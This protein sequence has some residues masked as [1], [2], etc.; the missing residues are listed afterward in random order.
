MAEAQTI[1]VERIRP[2]P[3]QARQHF[4]RGALQELADSIKLHGLLNPVLVRPAADG[5]FELVHGER[6]WRAAKLAGLD[7]VPATVRDLSDREAVEV[8]LTENLQRQD[9][10]AIEEAEA[11]RAYTED[12]GYTQAE[13]AARVGRTQGH[14]S[15]TLRLTKLHD[16]IRY[17]IISRAI[18]G[19]HGRELLG[20]EKQL[21]GDGTEEVD[22]HGRGLAFYL[23]L[24]IDRHPDWDWQNRE[25]AAA[26]GTV[27]QYDTPAWRFE[28]E[29]GL[30][31][32]PTREPLT[33]ITRADL[34]AC[35]LAAKAAVFGWSVA[36]LQDRLLTV[37]FNQIVTA[38]RA[39]RVPDMDEDTQARAWVAALKARTNGRGLCYWAGE[40]GCEEGIDTSIDGLGFCSHCAELYRGQKAALAEEG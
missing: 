23:A 37:A 39:E 27:L 9:L 3:H 26:L 15:N 20:M 28:S 31:G 8:M 35:D 32:S 14:I 25:Q 4:D 6:R 12:L 2:N 1:P 5:G 17:L 19:R 38:A 13:L 7:Q 18:S 11:F 34:Q 22:L 40:P 33:T 16:F 10:T 21:D 30:P 29:H 36:E 24:A